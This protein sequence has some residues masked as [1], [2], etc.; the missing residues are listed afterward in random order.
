MGAAP[1]TVV[2]GTISTSELDVIEKTVASNG[3]S[4]CL[5]ER[6]DRFRVPAI[7]SVH[8]FKAVRRIHVLKF[9]GDVSMRFHQFCQN[10]RAVL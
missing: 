1:R 3:I 8:Y 6:F 9:I 5:H 7:R 10:G 4:N 2:S